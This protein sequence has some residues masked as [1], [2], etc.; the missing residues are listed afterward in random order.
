[1][2]IVKLALSGLDGVKESKVVI[3]GAS[4]VYD[5]KRT[6]PGKIVGVVNEKTQFPA[7]LAAAFLPKSAVPPS[8]P[9]K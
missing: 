3:G 8:G 4:V 2:A 1:M 7:R 9:E 6:T 5:P